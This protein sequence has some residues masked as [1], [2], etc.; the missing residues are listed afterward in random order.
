MNPCPC[1]YLGDPSGRYRCTSKQVSRY[2]A[3][4]S[5][6]LLDRIDMHLEVP[7]VSHQVLRKGSPEGEETS[8]TIRQRVIQ[9]RDIAALSIA[10]ASLR[11]G[12]IL[13][14]RDA[15]MDLPVPGGPSINRLCKPVA[16]ISNARIYWKFA[17]IL[18]VSS[19]CLQK[20]AEPQRLAPTAQSW[21]SPMCKG[22]FM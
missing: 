1:G 6:P 9:A 22:S 20:S 12:K 14:K 10:C 5:G 13:D 16:A 8:A 15:N 19:A 11:G 4:I 3:K 7:R 2:R 18:M 21:I 17:P